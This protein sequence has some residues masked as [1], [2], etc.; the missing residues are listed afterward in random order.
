MFEWPLDKLDLIN[1]ALAQTR[2]NPVAAAD[3]G[4]DEWNTC[5]PAYERGLA[6]AIEAH[7]W[8]ACKTIVPLNPA[9]N[10]PADDM[11]DTAYNIPADLV[12]LI[13]V[14]INDVPVPYDLVAGPAG[15][16]GVQIIVRQ[17]GG[18]GPL[19]IAYVSSNNSDLQNA[20]PTFVLALQ[21]FVMSGIYRWRQDTAESNNMWKT[22]V[23]VLEQAKTRHDQQKPKRAL[24]NSRLRM[25][26]RVRRPWWGT[27]LDYGGTG[28][29][30]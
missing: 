24:H 25:A 6:F 14:R 2:G 29:P 26:R 10:V 22:A 12:H 3:N 19:V 13:W 20:T 17:Q 28:N 18:P 5:S 7:P 9:V 30:D 21:T 1:S 8:A 23:A 11:Y 27:P 15:G 16:S 4:S